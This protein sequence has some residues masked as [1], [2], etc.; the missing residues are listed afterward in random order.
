[1]FLHFAPVLCNLFV[2]VEAGG[3]RLLVASVLAGALG[4]LQDVEGSDD[5]RVLRLARQRHLALSVAG[6]PGA[7]PSE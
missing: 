4:L 7:C 6:A 1:M 2:P 3:T 5:G